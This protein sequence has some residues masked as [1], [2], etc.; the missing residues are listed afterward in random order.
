MFKVGDYVS[1]K[2]SNLSGIILKC[3]TNITKSNYYTVLINN[4]KM[5][6]EE[7]KLEVSNKDL[8]NRYE[9]K[10]TIKNKKNIANNSNTNSS[11]NKIEINYDV[12]TN[13]NFEAEIMLRHKN[14]D[15]AICDLENFINQALCNKVYIIKIIHGKS[16][17]ILRKAVHEYLKDCN[18]VVE[19]RLGNYFEGSYG[20]TIAQIK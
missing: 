14:V 13:E 5:N 9:N 4:K 7:N 19:Y 17:G 16:G 18:N 6:I 2:E 3:K 8:N 10:Y 20:V 15:E 1:I 11:A 12:S